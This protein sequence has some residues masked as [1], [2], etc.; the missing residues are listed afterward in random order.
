M[1]RAALAPAQDKSL[2]ENLAL[3]QHL[4]DNKVGGAAALTAGDNE[5]GMTGGMGAVQRVGIVA[6]KGLL[7]TPKGIVSSIEH[8]GVL[9]LG[10]T[11]VESGVVG[12][13]LKA[14][15][16]RSAPVGKIAALAL[17]T[18]FVAQTIPEYYEAFAKGLEAKTWGQ[19]DNASAKFGE[20]TGTL[21]IDTV[22]GFAGFKIGAGAHALKMGGLDALRPQSAQALTENVSE[23]TGRPMRKTA[24]DDGL[25]AQMADAATAGEKGAKG[26]SLDAGNGKPLDPTGAA[27]AE[28]R[29]KGVETPVAGK[30]LEPA[31]TVAARTAEAG[32]DGA[33]EK[34]EA[35]DNPI[36]KLTVSPEHTLSMKELY[37]TDR[38]KFE[39]VLDTYYKKLEEAFPDAS[40]IESKDVYREY[41]ADKSFP[42]DMLVLRDKAGN[43]LGGI[44]SQVVDVNGV[45][46]KKA[47]WAEHIW[48]DPTARTYTNFNTLLKTAKNT[49]AKTGSDI[50]FMEFNDRAKMTWDEQVAD[51]SAGLTP[52]A[53]ERIWG[54]VGLYVLG[55]ESRHLAPYSQ[56]AMGDG[57][58]VTYLS[59]GIGPLKGD[60]LDGQSMP[61]SDY[62]KLMRAAHSTIPDVNLD[63]DPTVLKYTADL[64][65]LSDSGQDRLSYARLRDTQVARTILGRFITKGGE[66]AGAE[67]P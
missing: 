36:K 52:E 58:P 59:M 25:L 6:G 35:G 41:L 44:Q 32:H 46:V 37:E 9:G 50:V 33:A 4:L 60:S 65:K 51:A 21:A 34:V 22:V 66:G 43:V 57:D 14:I 20:A 67:A 61:I 5:I 45:E 3:S 10:A 1:D 24:I 39:E 26:G 28:A 19:M 40:E 31:D 42:W 16:A 11:L 47:V 49:W 54:R 8:H 15:M 38:A 2:S 29:G 17:G 48:L 18:S 27:S 55:D 64:Q 12:F 13:G 62:L 23:G 56:P 7:E 30:H 63:T 53:R